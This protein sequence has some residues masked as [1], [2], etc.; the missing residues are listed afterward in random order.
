[1]Q[2]GAT[3][4]KHENVEGIGWS[5]VI[6]TGTPGFVTICETLDEAMAM[7]GCDKVEVGGRQAEELSR[8]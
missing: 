8:D 6:R 3:T 1:M 2:F 4:V 5:Y 7:L